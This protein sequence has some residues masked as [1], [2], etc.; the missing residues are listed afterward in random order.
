MEPKLFRH[1][2]KERGMFRDDRFDN[3]YAAHRL[4]T[5]KFGDST[6]KDLPPLPLGHLPGLSHHSPG[7]DQDPRRH[8]RRPTAA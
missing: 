8:L 1:W 2:G 6:L 3:G 5:E 4:F 7:R